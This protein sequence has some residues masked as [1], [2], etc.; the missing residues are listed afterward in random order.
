MKKPKLSLGPDGV[1]GLL[2][3]HVEKMV[4]G[5]ALLMVVV[6][7]YLGIR[8][9]SEL[10]NQTPDQLKVLATTAETYIA[11]PSAEAL[12]Q[13]RTPRDGKGGQYDKRV[14]D[15]G[16]INAAPYDTPIPWDPPA[17]DPGSKRE[18]PAT[19]APIKIELTAMTGP[20]CVKNVD[21]IEN[22]VTA[23][24]NAPSKEVKKKKTTRKRRSYGYEGEGGMESESGGEGSAGPG[25]GMSGPGYGMGGEEGGS[26]RGRGRSQQQKKIE[27][28]PRTYDESKVCGYRPRG[29]STSSSGSSYGYGGG[30][31]EMDGGMMSGYGSS[32]Y[33]SGSTTGKRDLTKLPLAQTQHVIA[34]KALAPFRK[35]ADEFKR[36]LGTAVGYNPKRDTPRY[37]F[38]QAQRADVTDD[39]SKELTDAD[40]TIVMTPKTAVD[41][42]QKENWDGI[43]PEVADMTYLDRSVSMPAPPMLL[44][45][46]EEVMLHSE[47]PK[48]TR[49]PKRPG[50]EDE[51]EEKDS[52]EESETD[53]SLPGGGLPGGGLPGGRGPGGYAGGSGFPGSGF[54]GS[55]F[56]GSGFPGGGSGYGMSGEGYG[57]S[58]EGSGY[59]YGGES[60]SDS[61]YGYGMSG[62]G[63]G[64]GYG[65][66][67]ESESDSG[68]G[69]S[70]GY[71]YGSSAMAEP[72][73]YKLVRFFDTKVQPG[74]IYRY[75]ICLFLEDPNNPNT[76]PMNGMVNPPPVRRT[77][78]MKV[79]DR[80]RKLEAA[81]GDKATPY[82]VKT[83]WSEASEPVS[84]P[85]TSRVFA[86]SVSPTKYTA[87]TG[88]IRYPQREPS[89][90]VVPVVFDASL[91]VD[92]SK[93]LSAGR[94]SVLNDA[95]TYEIL[96]PVTLE[97]KLLKSF[98]LSS[99]ITL[100]DMFGGEELPGDSENR[101]NSLGELLF[102]DQ[103]GNFALHDELSDYDRYQRF[104]LADEITAATSSYGYSGE[105][106]SDEE[107]GGYGGYPGSE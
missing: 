63:S 11:E 93:K 33:G 99:R 54:P 30:E 61:G 52:G 83:E 86:N 70:Y 32:G 55:G 74:R 3:K 104:T 88:G 27:P 19:F 20:M 92:V 43:M 48:S 1:K 91:A 53:N 22:P 41:V 10:G 105:G 78:S 14:V 60:E 13:A 49:L 68:Y 106:G 7:V 59:G 80:I 82:Y 37:I 31:S 65:Y 39:P 46:M 56:P 89:A 79:I 35:Q 23:L 58:G 64:Y 67:G 38:F 75:R 51:G 9:E 85:S 94:G 50:S 107:Y 57:M 29:V 40:W 72:V 5:V 28:P 44:R 21:E 100:L 103:Q 95:G 36:V 16:D 81:S 45:C 25:Y 97:I 47:V 4:F 101:V 2:I 6:F 18:D 77:L 17:G 96:D 87:G 8:L 62:E 102:I 71:G 84:I 26:R 15:L 12:R 24:E 98:Q 42:A 66:G 34:V 73:Q 69:G 90:D 76:D